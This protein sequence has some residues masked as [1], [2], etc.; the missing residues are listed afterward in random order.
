M[1]TLDRRLLAWSDSDTEDDVGGGAA[2]PPDYASYDRCGAVALVDDVLIP[3]T[4]GQC[5]H[6]GARS[7]P[8]SGRRKVHTRA[9]RV[10]CAQARKN[11]Q[12]FVDRDS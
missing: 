7:R 3:G 5:R 12:V 11:L 1:P 9:G 8:A 4:D 10:S 2:T 6:G